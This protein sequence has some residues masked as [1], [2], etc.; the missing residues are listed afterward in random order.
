MVRQTLEAHR[1]IDAF[2]SM[3]REA[4]QDGFRRSKDPALWR[5]PLMTLT[6]AMRPEDLD[7]IVGA[8]AALP[9]VQLRRAVADGVVMLARRSERTLRELF[10]N[11]EGDALK[12]ALLTLTQDPAHTSLL[13]AITLWPDLIDILFWPFA[14]LHATNMSNWF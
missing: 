7:F 8:G 9:D 6:L 11:A 10:L 13:H 2:F 12:I 4:I 3:L 5:G 1:R 14:I